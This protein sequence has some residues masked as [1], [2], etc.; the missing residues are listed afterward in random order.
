M[1]ETNPENETKVDEYQG[2]LANSKE[3]ERRIEVWNELKAN[4]KEIKKPKNVLL[5]GEYGTGK[6]SFINTVITALTGKYRYYADIGSGNLHSTT[7]LHKIS[8]KEYWNPENEED[9]ALN[10]PN[11]I[12]IIGLDVQL[13]NPYERDTV[14]SQI[15]NLILNGKL[16]EDTDLLDLGMKL[17]EGKKIVEKSED[18]SLVIDIIVIVVSLEDDK[19]PHTLLDE[20]YAE[21]KKRSRQ[22]PVFAVLTK[23]D[24]CNDQE[25][26]EKKKKYIAEEISIDVRKILICKN[27]HAGQNPDS[28][29]VE[30]LEFLTKLCDPCLKAVKLHKVEVEEEQATLPDT[31]APTSTP[32]PPTNGCSLM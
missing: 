22:F 19:I 18:E 29:D 26:L 30:I 5:L 16:S 14:N 25:K 20:I 2:S 9:R 21:S 31:V 6:S 10:L 28:R 11:F 23:S 8:C 27:Y 24:K 7:R 3:D 13:S 4:L 32:I 12:D 15:M 17:K 1:T